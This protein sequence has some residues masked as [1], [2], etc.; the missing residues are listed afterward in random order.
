[1]IASQEPFDPQCITHY[2]AHVYFASAAEHEQAARLR[3][4]VA[5]RFPAV[6]IGNWHHQPVGPHSQPMYQLAFAADQMPVVLPWL[7][8]NR[9]GLSIL[10]HPTTGDDYA[11]HAAYAAWLGQPLPLRL[12]SLRR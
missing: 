4:Q 9:N 7:M 5:E 2:H 10:L 11:D 1:M 12:D 3:E 6:R 8:L